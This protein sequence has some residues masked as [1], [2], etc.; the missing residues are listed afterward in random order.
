[1]MMMMLLLWLLFLP[2]LSARMTPHLPKKDN[3][4]L[5]QPLRTTLHRYSRR[6]HSH[7]DYQQSDPLSSALRHGIKSIE[8]DV[9]PRQNGLW[10]GHTIFELNPSRTIES[11]YIRPILSLLRRTSK[12]A[13]YNSNSFACQ[14]D[15]LHHGFNANNSEGSFVPFHTNDRKNMNNQQTN[16]LLNQE[17]PDALIL[18]VD[19][20]ANA[21]RSAA[22]LNEAIVP[23][24]PYLTRIDKA[25]NIHQGKIIVLISGNRPKPSS[26]YTR[27]GDRFLFL[28]GRIKDINSRTDTSLVPLVS[29]PWRRLL[30]AKMVGKR[31][32]RIRRMVD[33]AH[34][35]GKQLRIWGAPNREGA[36]DEMF[37]NQVDLLSVDDHDRFAR[38]AAQVGASRSRRRGGVTNAGIGSAKESD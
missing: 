9:Y 13:A 26:L 23:L 27:R 20:K 31:E 8:V 36:W 38:F 16:F 7:N 14:D 4:V 3:A 12:P 34:R 29:V 33:E 19:F 11:M 1:M 24:R 28:D 5:T 37:R 30:L 25:G 2:F 18:L 32:D 21:A 6:G 10:V 15:F 22:L 17:G 35:Q